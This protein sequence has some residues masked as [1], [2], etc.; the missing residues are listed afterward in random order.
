[1]EGPLLDSRRDEL[2]CPWSGNC[3][4]DQ[5]RRW[6]TLFSRASAS[7][8]W[9]S[10]SLKLFFCLTC[11]SFYDEVANFAEILL[12]QPHLCRSYVIQTELNESAVNCVG[13]LNQGG[14]RTA[15]PGSRWLDVQLWSF[16]CFL[17]TCPQKG[18]SDHTHATAGIS[19]NCRY[20]YFRGWDEQMFLRG[21]SLHK[22]LNPHQPLSFI[23][24][25][26]FHNQVIIEAR[27]R[28]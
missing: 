13:R 14:L 25:P 23:A 16:E 2:L 18:S 24:P 22:H 28:H 4:S 8:G 10:E 3:S 7:T 15:R 17:H 1:M 9:N 11:C 21:C 12:L 6:R 19:N 27:C 5:N 26:P 20:S